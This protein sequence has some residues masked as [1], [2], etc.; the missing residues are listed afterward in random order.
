MLTEIINRLS[1]LQEVGKL[2]RMSR[3]HYEMAKQDLCEF[4]TQNNLS[5]LPAPHLSVTRSGCINL[6]WARV[7]PP[8]TS[9]PRHPVLMCFDGDHEVEMWLTR[10]MP[11]CSSVIDWMIKDRVRMRCDRPMPDNLRAFVDQL[12]MDA[13][14]PT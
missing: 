13:G 3:T 1:S 10:F 6:A 11:Q 14:E 4:T 2:T 8:L 12:I 9:R 5:G 7:P